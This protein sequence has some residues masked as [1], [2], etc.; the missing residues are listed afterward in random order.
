MYV[1]CTVKLF[2][3][4]RLPGQ[5]ALVETIDNHQHISFAGIGFRGPAFILTPRR[6]HVSTSVGTGRPITALADH[7][8]Q[9]P[10]K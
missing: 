10:L 3:A 1:T 4:G 6:D 2:Q 5:L 8:T 9:K 7:V